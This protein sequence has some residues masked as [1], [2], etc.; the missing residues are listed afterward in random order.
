VIGWCGFLAVG[1]SYRVLTD[2]AAQGSIVGVVLAAGVLCAAVWFAVR[3]WW[4]RDDL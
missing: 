2:K 4:D 3:T 1:G